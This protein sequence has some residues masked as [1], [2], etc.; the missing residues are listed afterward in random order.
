MV[1]LLGMAQA[2]TS[3]ALCGVAGT[4]N[5]AIGLVLTTVAALLMAVDASALFACLACMALVAV[6]LLP[7]SPCLLATQPPTWFPQTP[8]LT[9]WAVAAAHKVFPRAKQ[10]RVAA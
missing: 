1:L 10:C 6:F 4:V 5:T 2:C 3:Q 8:S 7:T 9:P